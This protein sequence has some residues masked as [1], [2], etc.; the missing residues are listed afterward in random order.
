MRLDK[1]LS[2]AGFGARSQVK[3]LIRKGHVT[4]NGEVV[5]D[6]GFHVDPE[7]DEVLVDGEPVLYE[8]NYYIVLNKPAGYVTSTKDRELTVMELLSDIPRFE[9]LFPVGRLDKDAEGLLLLTTDGELAHRLTHPRWKV[10]KKYYVVV[11]GKLTEEAVEPLRKG[12]ELKN[13]KARPAKVKILKAGD[14]ESEAEIEITE[15]KYHQV[16]RMFAA[17]G[18]P[19][20]YLKRVEFGGLKLGELPTGQYRHLT[21]GEL[22]ALKALLGLK[23]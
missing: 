14:E 12:I 2:N 8:E 4:V 21:E 17:V 9:K 1:L 6:P 18:H 5:K 3:R 20:K 10:P 7:K 11:E 23:E 22:R 16:K 15:G 13:F 19:V